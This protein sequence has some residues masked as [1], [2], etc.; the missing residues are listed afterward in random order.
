MLKG[1]AFKVSRVERLLLERLGLMKL[2][3]VRLSFR[4][5]L[6]ESFILA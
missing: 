6:R 2:S 5:R 1:A 3:V 4:L